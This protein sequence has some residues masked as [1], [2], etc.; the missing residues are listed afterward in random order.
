MTESG[1]SRIKLRIQEGHLFSRRK[2]GSVKEMG[3]RKKTNL[4]LTHDRKEKWSGE[5][6]PAIAEGSPS[7]HPEEK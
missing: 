3:G 1:K 4:V 7:T 2:K 5:K 6:I